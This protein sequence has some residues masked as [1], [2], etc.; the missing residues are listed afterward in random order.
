M[1]ISVACSCGKRFRAADEFLGRQTNCPGC[2]Q[3]LV[4]GQQ[5]G[6]PP[7]ADQDSSDYVPQSNYGAPAMS[8]GGGAMSVPHMPYRPAPPPKKSSAAPIV[9]IVSVVGLAVVLLFCG[10]G[11]LV[12]GAIGQ[13]RQAARRAAA[14]RPAGVPGFNFGPVTSAAEQARHDELLE[15]FIRQ[16]NA[17]ADLIGRIR[18]ASTA[19]SL[20]SQA[21]QLAIEVQAT[22]SEAQVQLM[23]L[24]ADEDRRLEQKFGAQLKAAI[25]RAQAEDER[26]TR[27]A[28]SLPF[29][30]FSPSID[31]SPPGFDPGLPGG[32][33]DP[34]GMGGPT[35]PPGLGGGGFPPQPP[36]ILPPGGR[37]PP[38]PGGRV[39]GG[40][41]PPGGR[42]G[43]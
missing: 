16:L 11:W 5:P 2:G 32:V 18:D 10:V 19:D 1:A 41:S 27:L 42:R 22:Q 28:M 9:A 39:P 3:P 37:L 12:F 6:L 25:A 4:V 36:G 35:M 15:R 26:V 34:S 40:I 17:Y 8:L 24:P 21:Q 14:N 7:A 29:G 38:T 13:A 43:F 23:I 31:F 33:I 20:G 30:G